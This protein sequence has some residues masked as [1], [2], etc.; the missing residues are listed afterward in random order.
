MRV[1]EL[2]LHMHFVGFDRRICDCALTLTLS[3]IEEVLG[4]F[5]S[6]NG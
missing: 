5:H 6:E 2:G 4:V 1:V 3:E